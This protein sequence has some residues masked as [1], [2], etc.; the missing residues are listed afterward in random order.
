MKIIYEKQVLNLAPNSLQKYSLYKFINELNISKIHYAF[1]SALSIFKSDSSEYNAVLCPC[2]T[3][4][5]S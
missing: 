2:V 1:Q 5:S 3:V 4:D